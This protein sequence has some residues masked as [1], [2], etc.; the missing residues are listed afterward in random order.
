LDFLLGVDGGGTGCRA[1]IATASGEIVGRG[2][3][4]P[5]NIRTDLTGARDNIVAAAREA[6]KAAG[7][8]P[9]VVS[10][11]RAILGLAG[12]NVGDYGRQLEGLLPFAR[13]SVVSDALIALEGAVGDGGDGAIAIVGTGTAYLVRR[14]GVERALGGWGFQVGDQGAGSRIGREA[15]EEAL[16]AHDNVRPASP[17]S[18]AILTSFGNDPHAIVEFSLG[19]KPGDFAGFAP[20]VLEYA[21]RGDALAKEILARAIAAVEASLAALG[22]DQTTPLSLLGGLSQFYAEHL[23][24]PFRT[25]VRPPRTDALGGAVSMAVRTFGTKE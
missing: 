7:L 23:S 24:P 10:G 1:A 13:S 9:D 18:D 6:A 22:L 16:L 25:L 2:K 5:A 4:G 8:D 15:L 20:K 11:V 12:A 3:S 14:N 21:A 17:L 19:A